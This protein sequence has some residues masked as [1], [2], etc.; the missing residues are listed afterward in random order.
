MSDNG[1]D[2]QQNRFAINGLNINVVQWGRPGD[3]AIVMLHGLRSNART[4]DRVAMQLQDRFHVIAPDQRGRG[5][6]DWDVDRRYYTENYVDDL[7]KIVDALGLHHFI[8]IG[9]SMGG[10]NA[11]VFCQHNAARVRA[12]VIEDMGPGAAV[13]SAGAKRTHGELLSTPLSFASRE[14][15][16]QYIMSIRPGLSADAAAT[17]TASTTHE[18]PGGE[19]RWR[20]DLEGILAARLSANAPAQIDLW[21]ALRSVQVPTLVLRGQRSDY[22][23][24]ELVSRMRDCNPLVKV[25]TIADASHFVHDDNFDDYFDSL[26]SF[27]RNVAGQIV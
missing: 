18:L 2:P 12:L 6:S 4:W 13:S 20:Y 25:T 10:V 9:H 26:D 21:P 27:V 1:T 15:A 17:R 3:P 24:D 23:N 16:Q 19:V 7:L 8:L 22:L 5:L 11:L 14:L